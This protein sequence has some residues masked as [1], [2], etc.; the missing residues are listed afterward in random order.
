MYGKM[1]PSNRGILWEISLVVERLEWYTLLSGN[2]IIFLLLLKF[3]ISIY[4]CYL[5]IA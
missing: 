1:N 3:I 2:K 5:D 4:L